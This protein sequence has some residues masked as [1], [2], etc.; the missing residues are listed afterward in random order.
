MA[1]VK[2]IYEQPPKGDV[3]QPD[4]ELLLLQL[5]PAFRGDQSDDNGDVDEDDDA[6][7][8]AP[9]LTRNRRI[10]VE[11]YCIDAETAFWLCRLNE[12]VPL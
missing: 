3:E 10:S 4:P 12:G 8:R 6:D 5:P 1:D 11:V 9:H 7:V 2:V